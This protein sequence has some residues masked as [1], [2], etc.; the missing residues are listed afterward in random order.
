MDATVNDIPRGFD[1]TGFP[2]IYMVPTNNQPVKYEGQ[3][4]MSDLI[5][6]IDKYLGSKTEL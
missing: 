5:N 2:S 3:R 4:E 1:V 6:F